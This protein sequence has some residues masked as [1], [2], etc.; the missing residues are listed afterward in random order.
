M[1]KN[2]VLLLKDTYVKQ[3]IYSDYSIIRGKTSLITWKTL[4][5]LLIEKYGYMIFIK[6]KT[7]HTIFYKRQKNIFNP[8]YIYKSNFLKS[9][10]W[11]FF[12]PFVF[13]K[14]KW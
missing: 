13:R 6:C 11:R 4:H 10:K 12:F 3:I 7:K 14:K 5:M 1:I 9:L 8:H 2:F